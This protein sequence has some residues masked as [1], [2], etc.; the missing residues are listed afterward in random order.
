M[1]KQ[2]IEKRRAVGLFGL[3]KR[4]NVGAEGEEI[5]VKVSVW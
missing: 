1:G 2:A 5:G 4:L 3:E